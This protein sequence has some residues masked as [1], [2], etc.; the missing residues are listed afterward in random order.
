MNQEDLATELKGEFKLMPVVVTVLLLLLG[1]ATWANRY[2]ANVSVPRYCKDPQQAVHYLEKVINETR[3]AG[4][5]ARRPYLI[6]AKLLYLMP[7][8]S[9]ESIENYLSRVGETIRRECR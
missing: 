5:E 9:E 2:S 7:R 1:I 6:A 8:H 4:D 3:P